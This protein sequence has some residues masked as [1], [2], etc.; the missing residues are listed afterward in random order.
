[1]R[2]N[3]IFRKKKY[4]A[5]QETM[6]EV[7]SLFAAIPPKRIEI[8]CIFRQYRF[9]KVQLAI[10][11]HHLA[12]DCFREYYDAMDPN[13]EEVT[14]EHM[15][16][17]HLV[18]SLQ[19]LL[20]YG[21]DPNVFAGEYNDN[22]MWNLQYVDAPNVGAAAMRLLLEHGAN[23]NLICPSENESIFDYLDFAVSYD[24]YSHDYFFMVQCWLVLI[25]Y[26]GR[27]RCNRDPVVMLKNNSLKI[28]KNFEY[29][30]YEIEMLKQKSDEYGLWIMH[31][32]D[33]RTGTEVA[34]F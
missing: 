13:V 32:F 22:V 29:Y 26:G 8:D 10:L 11:A 18:E 12:E 25:G 33:V 2:W 23:P 1:M 14:P 19:Q 5:N 34:R 24:C 17:N 28:F 21:L 6:D 3:E 30:D 20:N 16:S 7:E 9:S 31:I 4:I 27:P 15:H